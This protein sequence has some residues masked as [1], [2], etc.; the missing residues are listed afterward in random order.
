MQLRGIIHDT[1]TVIGNACFCQIEIV[2]IR[3]DAH[4]FVLFMNNTTGNAFLMQ[5]NLHYRGICLNFRVLTAEGPVL[6]AVLN[7]ED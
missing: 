3:V 1:V 2:F 7:G 4:V 6:L 5:T